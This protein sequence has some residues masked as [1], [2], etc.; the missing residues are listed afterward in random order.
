[1]LNDFLP[2]MAVVL[3]VYPNSKEICNAICELIDNT[4]QLTPEQVGWM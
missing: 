4:M 1:M 3:S 2:R